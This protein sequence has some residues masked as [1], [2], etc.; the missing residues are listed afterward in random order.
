MI[1]SEYYLPGYKSGG[2]MRTIVNIVSHLKDKFEFYIITL[3]CDGNSDNTPYEGVDYESWNEV[4][5]AKVFYLNRNNINFKKILDLFRQVKPDIVYSNSYFSMFNRYLLI[6]NKLNKLNK[7]PY[8]ISPCGELT[9]DSFKV[10]K[11]KKSLYLNFA[12]TLKLNKSIIWK[13]STE[14]EKEQIEQI[15]GKDKR[16]FVAPDMIPKFF[17]ESLEGDEKPV[18]SNGAAKMVFLSRFNRKKNFKFL[19]E[20]VVKIKGELEIDIIGPINDENYW[21]ECEESIKRLPNNIK[22]IFK[23]S[24][25]HKDVIKTLKNYHFFVLPTEHENF[26][27]IFLEAFSA[28]CPIIISDRTPWLNLDKKK[29]GW[30]IPLENP[31]EW[32]NVIQKC[33]EMRAEEYKDLSHNARIFVEKWVEENDLEKDTLELFNYALSETS[34]KGIQ[35]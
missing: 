2:G 17:L 20:N 25:P 19:L 24:I 32:Q 28:G 14:V 30:S 13:A 21:K 27:H 5:D 3:D 11:T 10:G 6:L 23:G 9:R 22:V 31:S 26:G 33:V 16:I 15:L 8:I 12:E 29:V 7:L 4:E 34:T 35:F 1:F 18:K